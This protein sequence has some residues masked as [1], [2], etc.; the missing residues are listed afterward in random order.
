MNDITHDQ[1]P[2]AMRLAV[3][4]KRLQARLREV[5]G[6]SSTGL[7]ISQLAILKRL[8]IEGPAK[9]IPNQRYSTCRSAV[10]NVHAV[11]VD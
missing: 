3:A 11:V 5:V 4:I 2:V 6:A 8:R 10:C 9:Q 1:D 7:P